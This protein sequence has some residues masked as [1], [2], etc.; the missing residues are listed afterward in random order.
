M[1]D[2]IEVKTADLAGEALG[3]AVGKAEGLDLFLEPP[4]YN[5][6]PWRVFAR[7]QGEA[8]EH[9]KRYNPWEEWALGGP[10]FDKH[11]KGF[12]MLQDG[13]ASRYRAFAYNRPTGFS[14]LAGGPT[15]LTAGCRAIV[16]LKIGDT[17]QVP[18]ELMP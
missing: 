9:T 17:V 10:L 12:G 13:T 4:G 7:Y 18:K 15:I 2:M 1:T 14:R 3:W 5:G 8:I 16:A 11:C 6:V